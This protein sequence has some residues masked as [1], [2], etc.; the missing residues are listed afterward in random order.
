MR[1]RLNGWGLS[2][3]DRPYEIIRD[4]CTAYQAA[5]G[6]LADM[7]QAVFKMKGLWDAI[8]KGKGDKVKQR[9]EAVDRQRSSIKAIVIDAEEEFARISSQIQGVAELLG[10]Y[11]FLLGLAFDE[12][13]TRL[14]GM[15]P[16]GL[17]SSGDSDTRD[18][19][20]SIASEQ[21]KIIIPLMRVIYARIG[22]PL[23]LNPSSIKVEFPPLYEMTPKE[24]AEIE[25]MQA[26]TAN[27]YD[28][29]G[30]LDALEIRAHLAGRSWESML[31]ADQALR[32][33]ASIDRVAEAE[34]AKKLVVANP[35]KPV[36]GA[37]VAAE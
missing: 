15:S 29:I 31:D 28:T 13:L 6:L 14:F 7:S 30:S 19:Y 1:R 27:I 3:L 4:F 11:K 22:A 20:D 24:K 12:P 26:Q 5:G 23:G 2:V 35:A 16:G 33:L 10:E 32:E 18:W 21:R 36:P 37:P 25:Y 34:A 8:L 17:N 9:M